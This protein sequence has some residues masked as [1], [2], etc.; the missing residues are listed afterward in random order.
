MALQQGVEDSWLLNAVFAASG[1]LPEPPEARYDSGIALAISTE[2][3]LTPPDEPV[4]IRRPDLAAAIATHPGVPVAV[5]ARAAGIAA[6]AGLIETKD[7]RDVMDTLL[8]DPDFAPATPL[9]TALGLLRDPEAVSADQA[10]ALAAALLAAMDNPADFAAT[11]RLLREEIATLP[12]DSETAA[13]ALIFA[14]AAFAA[15]DTGTA[16]NWAIANTVSGTVEADSFDL[17]LISG[18]ILLSGEEPTLMSSAET[19]NRLVMEATTGEQKRAT[20][21]L[22][23]VWNE[24]GIA[25]PAKARAM[26]AEQDFAVPDLTHLGTLAAMQAAAE[27]DDPEPAGEDPEPG[28]AGQ[29]P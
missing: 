17:A 23:T 28:A 14:R 18:L 26:M 3:G 10:D 4:S 16:E 7:Y 22:M 20:A 11:A 25:P 1:E 21:R 6:A 13:H 2:A 9:E 15:G 8:D 19:G 5:R 12:M 27:A 29:P 24:T